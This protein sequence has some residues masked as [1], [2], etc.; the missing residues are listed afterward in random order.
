MIPAAVSS[1]R[2]VPTRGRGVA[3]VGMGAKEKKKTIFN[4][5]EKR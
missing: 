2:D 3:W 1:D 4:Q 5:A